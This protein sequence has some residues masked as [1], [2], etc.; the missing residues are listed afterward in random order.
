MECASLTAIHCTISCGDALSVFLGKR[1]AGQ[2]HEEAVNLLKETRLPNCTEKS[3]QFLDVIRLKS[4]VEYQDDEPTENEAR[5]LVLQARRFYQ[6][7]KQ[8]LNV[9]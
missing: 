9:T 7:A 4:L 1:Y 2:R 5:R 3:N 8:Q 6:W